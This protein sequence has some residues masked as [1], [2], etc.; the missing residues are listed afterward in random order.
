MDN[1]VYKVV[2]IIGSS[3]KSWDDAASVAI[4]RAS[5]SLRDIRI[6]EVVNQDLHIE[7]GK[8]SAYRVRLKISFKFEG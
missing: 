3:S 4:D 8:I 1:S 7:G 6:A 2:E 5:K